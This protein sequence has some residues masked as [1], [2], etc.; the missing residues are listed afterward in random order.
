MNKNNNMKIMLIFLKW[1]YKLD[2]VNQENIGIQF[3]INAKNVKKIHFLL[4]RINH[5]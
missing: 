1:N 4:A 3:I 2:F 5:A